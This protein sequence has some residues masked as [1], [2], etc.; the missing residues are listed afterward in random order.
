MPETW[1]YIARTVK[2]NKHH[3]VGCVVCASVDRPEYAADT[4]KE[5]A[6][7]IKQGLAVE[8]VPVEWVRKHLFTTVPYQPTP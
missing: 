6:K 3:P 8:R 4:A 5:V 7:W 2:E 1:A